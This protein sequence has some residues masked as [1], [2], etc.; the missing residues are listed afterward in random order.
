MKVDQIMTVNPTC[1]S[2]SDT[3]DKAA[4]IMREMD[5]GV[6]PVVESDQLYK[7]V[8]VVT[9]RDL[10]LNVVAEGRDP[11]SVTVGE[12]MSDEPIVCAP[13]DD[14]ELV[15]SLMQKHQ[16]RRIPVVDKE[17][18]IEG[19]VSTADLVINA[20]ASAEEVDKTLTE[21]SEPSDP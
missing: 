15:M 8:G 5:V 6:V 21:I 3:A 12:C 2:Q 4:G 13:D 1:C 19:I 20:D 17:G 7:L 9:D 14:I 11:K 16:I 10:C 18:R